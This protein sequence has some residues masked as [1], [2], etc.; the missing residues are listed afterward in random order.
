MSCGVCLCGL[1]SVCVGLNRFT[2]TIVSNT[3]MK[4]RPFLFSFFV[5]SEYPQLLFLHA[6]ML[7]FL[8]HSGYGL[9]VISLT[10]DVVLKWST[11][12]KS[13][14]LYRA[15]EVYLRL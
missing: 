14:S 9:S 3:R 12:I 6:F 7:P 5:M 11:P 8:V 10:K 4:I 2:I 13:F 15:A 1:C